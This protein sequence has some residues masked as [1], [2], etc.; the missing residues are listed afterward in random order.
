MYQYAKVVSQNMFAVAVDRPVAVVLPTAYTMLQ[1]IP[2]GKTRGIMVFNALIQEKNDAY[3]EKEKIRTRSMGQLNNVP[4]FQK[5]V[6]EAG[7]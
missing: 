7:A 6:K 1:M 3:V 4:A 5:A 2:V